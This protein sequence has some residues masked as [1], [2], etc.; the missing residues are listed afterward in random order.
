MRTARRPSAMPSATT[1]WTLLLLSC[2]KGGSGKERKGV[3]AGGGRN[4]ED[5]IARAA[6]SKSRG[7]EPGAA[8][9]K[10]VS[11]SLRKSAEEGR[12]MGLR[13]SFPRRR[14]FGIKKMFF[15][16]GAICIVEGG[17]EG[18]RL[19]R[20]WAVFTPLNEGRKAT[21]VL[22]LLNSFGSKHI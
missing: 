16:H 1:L 21:M 14:G 3:V 12:R 2:G 22:L 8:P 13:R 15:N 11:P 20:T 6:A 5:V 17:K 7:G 18:S 4:A 19:V 9:R 10:T